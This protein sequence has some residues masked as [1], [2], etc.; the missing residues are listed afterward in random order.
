[1]NLATRIHDIHGHLL[2]DE[3]LAAM[4]HWIADCPWAD[5]DLD[6]IDGMTNDDVV[7]GVLQHYAGGLRAFLDD[8]EV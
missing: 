5:L 8:L 6:D 4:R 2:T 3:E 7:L 1:M